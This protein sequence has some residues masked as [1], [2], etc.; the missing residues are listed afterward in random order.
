MM[1]LKQLAWELWYTATALNSSSR[2]VLDFQPR[3]L[4][5]NYKPDTFYCWSHIMAKGLTLQYENSPTDSQK[6]RKS[7]LNRLA[8][9]TMRLTP[10]ITPQPKVNDNNRMLQQV[11][12]I[13]RI[14]RKNKLTVLF[15]SFKQGMLESIASQVVST[16][17]MHSLEGRDN[18]TTNSTNSFN[19]NIFHG[20]CKF[21]KH[22]TLTS[23]TYF[24]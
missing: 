21:H 18:H 23:L 15:I 10:F 11:N 12:N 5:G 2:I 4:K 16:L 20:Q 1:T 8:K 6:Q 9:G 19:C 13:N 22:I 7:W 24:N 3:N 14:S 17:N